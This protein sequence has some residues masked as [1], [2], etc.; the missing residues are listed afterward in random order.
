MELF[1]LEKIVEKAS[2]QFQRF[3]SEISPKVASSRTSVTNFLSLGPMKIYLGKCDVDSQNFILTT[4]S[5]VTDFDDITLNRI[6]CDERISD[7]KCG[8]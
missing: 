8:K 2:C 3:S 4:R 1:L 6:A 7:Q 5:D